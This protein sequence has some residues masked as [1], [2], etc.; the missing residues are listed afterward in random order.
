M[1]DPDPDQPQAPEI[2]VVAGPNGAGKSTTATVLLPENLRIDQFVNADLIAL[3]LSPFAPERSAFAA[4]RI[5]L[6]RIH[7][8]SEEGMSFAFETTLAARS[9]APFLREAK[10]AGYLVHVIYI[11]LNSAELAV[12]RVAHRVQQGGH[13]VPRAV[14]ERRYQRGLRNLFSIYIPLANSWTLCDNS[15]REL[16]VV[17]Q[18]EGGA[19]PRVFDALKYDRIVECIADVP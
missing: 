18:G 7:K 19:E 10:Q 5:M 3:G 2:V 12:A 11:W 14:I 17:A 6:E 1:P 15:G 4:G 16:I 8:L 13:D 9:Y